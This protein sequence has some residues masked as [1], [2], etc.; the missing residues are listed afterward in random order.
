L[1]GLTSPAFEAALLLIMLYFFLRDGPYFQY[2]LRKVSPLT[3]SQAENL[4]EKVAKTMQ[5]ALT[6]LLAVALVQ[7]RWPPSNTW[8]LGSPMQGGGAGSPHSW[9]SFPL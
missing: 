7:V 9:C 4:L 6:S 3:G 1:W 5:G 2:Q 8:S